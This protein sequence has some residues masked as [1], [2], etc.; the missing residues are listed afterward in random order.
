MKRAKP[1]KPMLCVRRYGGY[2]AGMATGVE[3]TKVI[4]N[5]YALPADVV[6]RARETI[7]V[8]K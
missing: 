2:A 6:A 7:S 8:A 4:A 1:M 3:M 5:A